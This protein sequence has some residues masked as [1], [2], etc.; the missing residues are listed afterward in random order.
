MTHD[1]QT[2]DIHADFTR[3]GVA[4]THGDDTP[5]VLV[6]TTMGAIRHDL[7]L[8]YAL[9]DTRQP[10]LGF[11]SV[12]AAKV[13]DDLARAERKDRARHA[14]DG[15]TPSGVVAA[16][17]SISAYS[18]IAEWHQTLAETEHELTTRLTRVGICHITSRPDPTAGNNPDRD[19]ALLYARVVDLIAATTRPGWLRNLHTHLEDLH[20]RITRCIDGNQVKAMPDPCP[21]CGHRT[22]VAD[23]TTGVIRCSRDPE[24]GNYQSCICSD[25]YCA[26]KTPTR[27]RHTWHRDHK[28]HKTTS[29]QGLR[30]AINAKEND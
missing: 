2:V 13:Q 7:G 20:T 26:C 11:L 1:P 23:L 28:P 5:R 19:D 29:W 3:Y 4:H 10:G 21:W 27:E 22:L 6:L 12:E 25:S 8:V 16:P 14:R 9:I 30:R 15:V 24:T 18:L 17:G